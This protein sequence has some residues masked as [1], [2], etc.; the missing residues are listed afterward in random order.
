VS[1]IDVTSCSDV[2]REQLMQCGASKA[3]HSI[4]W[5]WLEAPD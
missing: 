5:H 1:S 3:W 4:L 2:P